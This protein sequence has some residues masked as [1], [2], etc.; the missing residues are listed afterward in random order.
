[1]SDN[2]FTDECSSHKYFSQTLNIIFHL[3]M[4]AYEI[5]LYMAIKRTSGEK[6]FSRKGTK[7]LALESGMS[8][9]KVSDTK[10][11]LCKPR[12]EL[13]GKSLIRIQ[14]NIREDGGNGSD[15]IFVTDIWEDNNRFFS[16]EIKKQNTYSPQE[17]PYS[18]QETKK[19]P[20]KKTNIEDTNV[21][22]FRTEKSG[23]GKPTKIKYNRDKKEFENISEEF[24][25]EL[26]KVAPSVNLDL[27]FERIKDWLNTNPS[28]KRKKAFERF[29]KSWLSKSEDQIQYNNRNNNSKNKKDLKWELLQKN[30]Y[31]TSNS[32][33]SE[34]DSQTQTSPEL[35]S[36]GDLMKS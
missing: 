19:N 24:I 20:F 32:E 28:G 21:S 13:N 4:T 33:H 30:K 16:S 35:R 29:L 10:K 22:S 18:P 23:S 1:M 15:H 12:E 26:K 3:G 9:H 7:R 2:Q 34:E 25:K 27:E 11:E 6:G 5:A 8:I 31:M 17:Q 14:K 36:L